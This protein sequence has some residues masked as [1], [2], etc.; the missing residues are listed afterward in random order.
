MAIKKLKPTS[1]GV[2]DMSVINYKDFLSSN[3]NEPKKSLVFGKKNTGARNN[4][5]RITTRFRGGG[6]KKNFRIIDFKFD[7]KDILA[8][9]ETVEYDPFRTAF[10][11]L[12]C[13]ADGER[14]Y[15]LSSKKSK[16]GDE[17]IVSEKAD[18]KFGNRMALKNIPVGTF[19]YNVEIKPNGG[20]KLARSAGSSVEM[21]ALDENYVHLK[22][23]SGEVRKV[24][25][26][27]F[28]TIGEASNS[29]HKLVKIGKAGRRRHMGRRP[30][31][32]GSAMNPVDHPYGGGEGKAGVGRRR[33][34][35]K[36]GK[37]SGKGQKTRSP[38]KYS[39]DFVVRG[40]NYKKRK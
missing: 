7:K 14:R 4:R 13:Y 10:I 8:K 3:K 26:E 12:V 15:I 11:S 24:L 5:G 32:R 9:I 34:V 22:M 37:A 30:K 38:K 20:A 25:A 2:R 21:A 39:N 36:W 16:V 35:T 1:N 31:V 40:R 17:F 6:N 33:L 29:D 19:V 27:C 23:P 28:A 18:P